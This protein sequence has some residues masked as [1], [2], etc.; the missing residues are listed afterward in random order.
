MDRRGQASRAAINAALDAAPADPR[1]KLLALFDFQR[2]AVIDPGFHGCPVQRTH[3]ELHEPDHPAK[4]ITAAHR[5][6]LLDLFARL[7]K[8]ARLTS[9]DYVAGALLVLAYLAGELVPAASFWFFGAATLLAAVGGEPAGYVQLRRRVPPVAGVIGAEAI[10]IARFYVDRPHHGRG[11]AHRLMDAALA[12]AAAGGAR[13]VWLQVAEYND[14][15]LAFYRKR[16][17]RTVGRVPFD[18][19]G[20]HESDHLM[21]RSGEQGEGVG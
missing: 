19:A 1:A 5:Q 20:V 8:E 17:F 6:W 7:V 2:E 11:V 12:H 15:A 10:E 9:P 4:R 16:G 14:R 13:D 3:A 18:F 21:A